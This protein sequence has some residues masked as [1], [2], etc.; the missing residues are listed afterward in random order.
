MW[1]AFWA[2]D[3]AEN[4]ISFLKVCSSYPEMV[5]VPKGIGDDY[6]RISATF[7]DGGRFP[8]LSY[9]HQETKVRYY[10]ILV[11]AIAID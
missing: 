8:V 11:Q 2:T 9:Y 7:R 1:A 6:L 4:Q 10:H 5:I 3:I